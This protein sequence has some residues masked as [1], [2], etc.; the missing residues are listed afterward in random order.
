MRLPKRITLPF[1]Y[2]VRIREVTEGAMREIDDADE[3][4]SDGCW[5]EETRTIY[6]PKTLSPRRKRYI[7]GHEVT[8]C[9][10]DWMHHCLNE[11]AMKP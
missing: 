2:T 5:D 6:I 10:H 8:H 1:G 11:E 7:L 9:V 4:F 3:R